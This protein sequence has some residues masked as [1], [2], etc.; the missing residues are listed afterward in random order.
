MPAPPPP[1][2][3]RPDDARPGEA[4]P[5]ETP[6]DDT[7]VVTYGGA[8]WAQLLS[9]VAAR[10]GDGRGAQLVFACP[11]ADAAQEALTALAR[12]TSGRV[13]QFALPTLLQDQRRQTQSSLR[14]AFD[15]AAEEAAL[16]FFADGDALFGWSHPD[17][18]QARGP[19]M[20]TV[21]EYL[22]QRMAAYP[23]VAALH[24]ADDAHVARARHYAL[25]AVVRFPAR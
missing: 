9:T 11:S 14:K 21:A 25:D 17:G 7:P 1:D 2:D 24:L 13:H 12:R 23:Q 6:P 16:L 10:H 19:Q 8:A 4:L 5:D 22:F 15:A 20:P 3:A 18:A